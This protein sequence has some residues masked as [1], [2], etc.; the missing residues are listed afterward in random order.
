[1]LRAQATLDIEGDAPRS[2]S[3]AAA[4]APEQALRFDAVYDESF[5]FVWRTVRRLGVGDESIDDVMQDVFFAVHRKLPDFAGRSSL[6]TWIFAIVLHVVRHHRRSWSRKDAQRAPAALTAI[7]DLPDCRSQGPLQAAETADNVRLLD[8]LLRELDDD[9]REVFVLAHLEQMTAP[10]IAEATGENVNTVYS[11]LRA[12]KDQ[13][14]Q[15]LER[16]RAREAWR[17]R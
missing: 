16:Q 11:R 12:A 10:E 14:E 6:R 3:L 17:R 2:Q 5:D 13:F 15:A 9:K 8:R 4:P 7:D 1:M